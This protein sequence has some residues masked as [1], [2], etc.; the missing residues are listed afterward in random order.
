M[1][2]I[3]LGNVRGEQGIQG[4][5][6]EKGDKGERG[7]QGIQGIQGI[8]GVQGATGAQG[9]QG[10]QG[11]PGAAAKINGVNAL[12]ISTGSGLKSSQTGST[13]TMSLD[14]TS[15]AEIEKIKTFSHENLLDNWY[16]PNAVNQRGITK[17]VGTKGY[18]ID[19]WRKYGTGVSLNSYVSLVDDGIEMY[20]DGSTTMGFVQPVESDKL[21]L[22]ET[23]TFS[24]LVKLIEDANTTGN[25]NIS[26]SVVGKTENQKYT[27]RSVDFSDFA[28]ISFTFSA[29]EPGTSDKYDV[30][31]R[32][33]ASKKNIKYIV[34]A[35]KLERGSVST[36]A[37]KDADGKWVLNEIPDYGEQLRRC[38]RYYWRSVTSTTSDYVKLPVAVAYTSTSITPGIFLPEP[39]RPGVTPTVSFS[40]TKF[41]LFNAAHE[42]WG[43]STHLVTAVKVEQCSGNYVSITLTTTDL[44]P[45]TAY[46]CQIN[47]GYIELSADL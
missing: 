13:F 18:F 45:G 20:S 36:L 19:R 38:Q 30:R 9:K 21:I 44:V 3:D 14:D 10:I 5:K 27:P 16:F 2:T 41:A 37:H 33:S 40:A 25:F 31:I 24:A 42:Y 15:S 8:P 22:G 17:L 34:K 4:E 32:S 7:E 11:E 47:H 28:V 35:M 39:M 29:M 6:G 43:N 26:L 23:Y 1:A 12:T 46:D